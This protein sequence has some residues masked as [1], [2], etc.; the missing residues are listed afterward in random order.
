M[1]SCTCKKYLTG[2]DL[3]RD[4][5]T[6]LSVPLPP[7]PTPPPAPPTPL[8]SAKTSSLPSSSESATA[9]NIVALKLPWLWPNRYRK[10]RR[11]ANWASMEAKMWRA[12][13]DADPGF[14]LMRLSAL[15]QLKWPKMMTLNQHTHTHTHTQDNT[16]THYKD[17]PI[18][19]HRVGQEAHF[20]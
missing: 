3:Y 9:W 11:S 18:V 15:C 2:D 6:S 4:C 10:R 1:I 17:K 13:D 19:V 14:G 5:S 8:W 16:H 12:T 20:D 7:P